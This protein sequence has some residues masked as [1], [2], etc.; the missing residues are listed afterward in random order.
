MRSVSYRHRNYCFRGFFE[1]Q[2]KWLPTTDIPFSVP[3]TVNIYKSPT[4][5]LVAFG[6]GSVHLTDSEVVS[7]LQLPPA[8]LFEGL[9]IYVCGT[10]P[11]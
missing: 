2:F 9:S 11:R 5:Q 7:W 8:V 10:S 4:I 1:L 3:L 6:G